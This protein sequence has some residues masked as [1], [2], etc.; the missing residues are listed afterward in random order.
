MWRRRHKSIDTDPLTHSVVPDFEESARSLV[1]SLMTNIQGAIYRVI[2]NC[3]S[4]SGSN[5]FLER[6]ETFYQPQDKKWKSLNNLSACPTRLADAGF[7]YLKSG[8]LVQCYSCEGCL[9]GWSGNN[10]SPW[11]AHASWF[12]HC[13]LVR[14]NFPPY[15]INHQRRTFAKISNVFHFKTYTV[16]IDYQELRDAQMRVFPVFQLRDKRESE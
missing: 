8:D 2:P 4:S 6:V 11:E 1:E 3:Y 12:P 16:P 9:T 10:I 14:V 7:S 15:Y 13:P 5:S